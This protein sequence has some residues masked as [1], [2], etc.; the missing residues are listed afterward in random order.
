MIMATQKKETFEVTFTTKDFKKLKQN[1]PNY[2]YNYS[3]FQQWAKSFVDDVKSIA[4]QFC[5]VNIK[6]TTGAKK[7]YLLIEEMNW[8]NVEEYKEVIK[9]YE[10]KENAISDLQ[11]YRGA[12]IMGHEEEWADAKKNPY[13]WEIHDEPEHFQMLDEGMGN[14]Y[15]LIIQEQFLV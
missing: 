9:V 5:K 4:G 14:N 10:N 1:Y 11:M 15:E 2:L 6:R 8:G 12:F 3:T 13:M 7:I